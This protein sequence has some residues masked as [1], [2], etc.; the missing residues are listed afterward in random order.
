METSE[1]NIKCMQKV[2]SVFP[3]GGAKNT[4]LISCIK[5]T[6]NNLENQIAS[7]N[8]NHIK[9]STKA[10]TERPKQTKKLKCQPHSK[11]QICETAIYFS[12]GNYVYE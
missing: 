9:L 6:Y 4:D 12:R 2:K 8:F 7:N 1:I 3:N 10:M 5:V 11:S